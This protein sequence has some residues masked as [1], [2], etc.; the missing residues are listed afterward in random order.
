MAVLKCGTATGRK[1]LVAQAS[2]SVKLKNR[3]ILPSL[4]VPDRVI[5]FYALCPTRS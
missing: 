4:I 1:I 2:R 5:S 3:A